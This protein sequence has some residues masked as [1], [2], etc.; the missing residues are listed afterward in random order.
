MKVK[1]KKFY[2][3][4]E[5]ILDNCI[6]ETNNEEEDAYYHVHYYYV[7][8][9]LRYIF[10]HR[11]ITLKNS[12]YLYTFLTGFAQYYDETSG[13]NNEKIEELK[14]DKRWTK[15]SRYVYKFLSTYLKF[16]E[17]KQ[18]LYIA[19]HSFWNDIEKDDD[20]SWSKREKFSWQEDD[21]EEKEYACEE[22]E[23]KEEDDEYDDEKGDLDEIK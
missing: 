22:Y 4:L 5:Q 14:N 2:K 6:K 16:R 12:D 8:L 9:D 3:C 1:D 10:K 17:I 20:F 18:N 21:E 7:I 23:Y 15:E 19:K 11:K 13:L